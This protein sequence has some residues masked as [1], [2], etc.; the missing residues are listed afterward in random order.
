[1]KKFKNIFA[2]LV[3]ALAGLSLTACSE[4]N[5]DTNQY[6]NDVLL[7]VYGP[8]PVMRGGTLR[9]LG[10]NLDQV[11]QVELP[12]VAAI[13]TIE[14]VKAGV[15]SEIRIQVPHDGPQE[16][17][18]KLTTKSG[19]ELTTKTELRFTEGLDAENI[20]MPAKAMPGDVIR[21]SVPESGDDY[22]DLI[23]M[24]EFA[25]GVQVGEAAFTAHTR[26]VIELTVPEEAQTGKLN[27]YTADL[28]T[29]E[30]DANAVD[31]QIIQTA[32]AL[33]VGTPTISKVASPRGEA[34]AQGNITAKAGETITLTGTYFNLVDQLKVG[35]VTVSEPTIAG[36]AQTVT[37][38]LPAEAPDGD[39]VI[40]CK[41]GVE[42]TVATVTTIVPTS[43]VA[44][45]SP[46]KA[47]Q[48]L[49]IK[50]NDID[51][52][53]AVEFADAKGEYTLSI[54]ENLANS[55]DI[56][57]INVPEEAIEGNLIL[58]M[59]NGKGVEVPFTLVKP[60]ATGYDNASVSAGGAL[61]IK[62]TNLDLIKKVQFGESDVVSVE[63]T[64]TAITLTVPMNA[65]SGKPVLTLAN[66][67]TIEAPELSIN[68]ALFCYATVL[69]TEEDELKAG[70]SM[71]LLVANG[72]K[73]TGVEMNGTACQWI[74]TGAEK[75]QL[76]IG[77]PESATASSKL[78]LISSNGEITYNIA[79]IPA[80]SVTKVIWKGLTQLT[81]ND[82]GR[83]LLPA[84]AFEG[85]PAGAVM[86]LSYSQVDQQWD[87]AQ[88]NYGDWSG[89]NF[90]ESGEGITTFS[91]TLVPT[92]VYGW[93]E[94]GILDRNTSVI[95]TQEILDNIQAKKGD[96]EDV[97]ACGIIIQGSGLTFSKVAIS[98]ENS[99]ETVVWTGEAVADNWGDQ[100]YILSDGGAELLAAGMKVGSVIRVY[101]TPMEATWN[102]QIVDGHWDPNTAFPEC[103]FSSDSWN[104]AE[105]NGAIEF[106]VTDYIYKH[107]TTVGGW[108]GSFLLNGD[109]V[110]CTKVTIQ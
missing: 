48:M 26:Y 20:T 7:N 83:V 93:F 8:S 29:G 82:G 37:F 108:G 95:L 2:L 40:V 41:S 27:L 42:V 96:C 78:R 51:L 11:A 98:Y 103:D 31:Y 77:I 73:L 25:D 100:P 49:T 104:L 97:A 24:V 59:A 90:T 94:D 36:N 92:D 72:D 91:Q 60:T 50:G 86:T 67:T 65:Q 16:G 84:S 106:T 109:N 14:V 6:Q 18:V 66:G 5:L 35:G 57:A 52:T 80:T 4:D 102:C 34:A 38:A 44:T 74:L 105:H 30:V 99:L 3:V 62:G 21:L 19:K 69:P 33:E 12:G 68:E 61:T 89:I 56:R 22:L 10:S 107:I 75:N 76:I 101:L 88:F 28:T 85:I 45:P 58:R 53:A 81:W 55:I 13:T 47:G 70:E 54:W 43:A 17:F 9:F 15:P 32:T 39:I 63:G 64:E 71:S 1:M 110:I 87:Q 79:V 46:V 23:H